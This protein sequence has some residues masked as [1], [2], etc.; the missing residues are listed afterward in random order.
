M[1]TE[2]AAENTSASFAGPAAELVQRCVDK[3]LGGCIAT[4]PPELKVL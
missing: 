1:L 2:Q 4:Y 3:S